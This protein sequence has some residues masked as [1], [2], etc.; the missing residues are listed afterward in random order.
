[1]VSDDFYRALEDRFRG[2][3]E[4]IK[5]RQSVYLPLVEAL[6]NRVQKKVLDVG[7]GRA[8]W[9]ELLGERGVP[10]E[11]LDLNEDFVAEGKR[12][13]LAVFSADA[14][15]YLAQQPDQSYGL[16]SAFHVVEHLGFE[17]LLLFL[18]EAYRV[19]DD[20]GAI[21]LETP[22]PANLVVG[23]CNFYLDPTHERPIPSILLSFAAEFSGF[24]RVVIVPVNRGFLQNNLELMPTELSGASVINKV[25]SSLD[26]NFMQAPDYAIIAFKKA[27]NELVEVADSLVSDSPLPVSA[28]ETEDVNALLERVVEAEAERAAL[29]AEAASAHA[30]LHD[31]VARTDDTQLRLGEAQ[32]Q[33]SEAQ[34]Q[35]SEALGRLQFLQAR[36][37]DA[38]ERADAAE[39]RANNSAQL[40]R[41]QELEAQL[42]ATY[43]RAAAAEDLAHRSQQHVIALLSSS[44]WR[45]SAPVRAVG[46]VMRKFRG[47]PR[48]VNGTVK[49]VMLHAV[50]YV[51]CRP[52]L[53]QRVA[54]LL[55]RFPRARAF[56]ARYVGFATAQNVVAGA[57]LAPVE[58]TEGLTTRGRAIYADLVEAKSANTK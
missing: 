7:C 11:G 18:R 10:A 2:S 16:I 5:S 13:G 46:T 44:S 31:A 58:S 9:L 56:V 51:Q 48:A 24:E 57:P 39:I 49:L 38:R 1:M 30:Q 25:V 22:N 33:L 45:L 40:Q 52:V 23:A 26:Q 3:R 55:A 37:A 42:H 36:L 21:L 34:G 15:Q 35:L 4:L 14:M 12:A 20:G 54:N 27:G 29:R 41:A 28:K 47:S 50:A 8:E 32:G 19:V 17:N 6:A 43:A 53:K